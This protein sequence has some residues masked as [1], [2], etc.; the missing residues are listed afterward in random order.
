MGKPIAAINEMNAVH[1]MQYVYTTKDERWKSR[2]PTA[3]Y[4]PVTFAHA[5]LAL[6]LG[7]GCLHKICTK[8]TTKMSGYTVESVC[9][10]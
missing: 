9:V 8:K 2:S 5:E 4:V 6:Y 7:C 3:M 1:H 10:T